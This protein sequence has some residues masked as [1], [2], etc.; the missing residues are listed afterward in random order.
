MFDHITVSS[1]SLSNALICLQVFDQLECPELH[2]TT[3]HMTMCHMFYRLL[4]TASYIQR[5]WGHFLSPEGGR[6]VLELRKQGICR[7]V[8]WKER[9]SGVPFLIPRAPILLSQTVL[10]P[11][12]IQDKEMIIQLPLNSTHLKI[13]RL[14]L[15]VPPGGEK[16]YVQACIHTHIHV[17]THTCGHTG[18]RHELYCCLSQVTC[19]R[20]WKDI[21]FSQALSIF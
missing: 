15:Y 3:C 7:L 4:F 5:W 21:S 11:H 10:C 8:G 17:H 1:K 18:S 16:G 9:F 13:S 19:C 12:R 20:R 14:P 2:N 6:R